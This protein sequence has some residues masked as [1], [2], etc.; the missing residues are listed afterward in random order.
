[1]NYFIYVLIFIYLILNIAI[2]I[3]YIYKLCKFNNSTKSNK[4]KLLE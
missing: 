2:D 1:M 4:K 3:I